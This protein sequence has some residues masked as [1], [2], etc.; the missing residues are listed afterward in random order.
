[1]RLL[2]FIHSICPGRTPCT[3]CTE[4]LA[5]TSSQYSFSATSL[6]TPLQIC[7]V[8]DSCALHKALTH[9]EVDARFTNIRWALLERMSPDSFIID[10]DTEYTAIFNLRYWRG[11]EAPWGGSATTAKEEEN[12][13]TSTTRTPTGV[14]L[15]GRALH[16]NSLDGRRPIRRSPSRRKRTCV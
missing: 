6:N 3:D 9:T 12:K 11:K 8:G 2:P 4:L 14:N 10:S 7:G 1:M 5:R 13:E 16:H 15:V